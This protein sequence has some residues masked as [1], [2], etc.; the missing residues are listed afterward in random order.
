MLDFDLRIKPFCKDTFLLTSRIDDMKLIDTLKADIDKGVKKHHNNY[1]TNVKGKMTSFKYFNKNLN[2]QKFISLIQPCIQK[3]SP[4]PLELYDAWGNILEEKDY[5]QL[6]RHDPCYLSGVLYL[7]NGCGTYFKHFDT[8]LKV[9]PG[10]FVLFDS[11]LEHEVKQGYFKNKRYT[12]AFNFS[13]L[14]HDYREL[15]Q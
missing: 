1:K 14:P 11:N 3:V 15:N 9:E 7:S 10:A 5:V 4:R 2:F 8:E 13:I 12:L 6:H